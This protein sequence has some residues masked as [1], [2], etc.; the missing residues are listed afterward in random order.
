LV[1]VAFAFAFPG[2]RGCEDV[3]FCRVS[4]DR[5][6][7]AAA[8]VCEVTPCRPVRLVK[9]FLGLVIMNRWSCVPSHGC[10]WPSVS[11][12][13]LSS[14]AVTGRLGPLILSNPAFVLAS[15]AWAS[16]FFFV[17]ARMV[18]MLSTGLEM[19]ERVALFRFRASFL[20]RIYSA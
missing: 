11:S 4:F 14:L 3:G 12:M 19:F 20:R 8:L 2:P 9:A 15:C 16:S 18:V 7:P 6:Y 13:S 17:S 10:A 1:S 5:S